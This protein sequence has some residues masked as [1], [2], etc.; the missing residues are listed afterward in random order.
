MSIDKTLIFIFQAP[1]PDSI[2]PEPEII[3]FDGGQDDLDDKLDE[4]VIAADSSPNNSNIDPGAERI[5]LPEAL[6]DD[7]GGDNCSCR[8]HENHK[9]EEKI[10]CIHCSLTVSSLFIMT[11]SKVFVCIIDII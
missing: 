8:C 11:I 10:H 2:L 6:N 9:G 1:T 3:D 5:S 7:F 4:V